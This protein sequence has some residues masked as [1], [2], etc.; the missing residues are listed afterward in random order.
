M[1]PVLMACILH[2]ASVIAEDEYVETRSCMGTFATIRF[3]AADKDKTE[4]EKIMGE[5]F[6]KLAQL[7]GLWSTYKEESLI[8]KINSLAYTQAIPLDEE[9]FEVINRSLYFNK[10]TSGAFDITVKPLMDYWKKLDERD[11][12]PSPDAINRILMSVG[13]EKIALGED[14][15][16]RFLVQGMKLDL[17]GIAKGFAA[18]IVR[19]RLRQRGIT[20]ALINL[21]GDITA[22]GKRP[23]GKPWRVGIQD[24]FDK[25]K[26][27]GT[28]EIADAAVV[29]SGN[30]ERYFYIR[31]KRYSH[32]INPKTGR[33]CDILPSVTVVAPSGIDADALATAISVLGEEK[34]LDLVEKLKDTECFVVKGPGESC[35][36]IQ[37]SG[38]GKFLSR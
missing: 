14:R 31:G 15:A 27:F 30:Y 20:Q 23:G 16:I 19:Q 17:G 6:E 37:S 24:P 18:D 7:D 1:S 13:S 25:S 4:A 28:L 11:E 22:L 35:T 10:L 5:A 34:G 8:S 33:P 12:E 38:F 32:I 9:T 3:F 2:A 26:L 36:T 29:T 21:G